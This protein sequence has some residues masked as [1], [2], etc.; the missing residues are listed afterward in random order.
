M[1]F[2]DFNDLHVAAGLDEV[3]RQLT[4]ALQGRDI[5][6]VPPPTPSDCEGR[7]SL[8]EALER[9]ILAMPD[10][11]V[12]DSRDK[13]LLR[14]TAARALMGKELFDAWLSNDERRSVSQE[15][16]APAAA[17]KRG[18]G[19]LSRALGRYVYLY[20]TDTV[21]DRQKRERVSISSL[22]YA[23]AKCY[24]DWLKHPE[25]TEIDVEN[26]VF[27]PTQKI[28]PETHIN[29]FR[30]L[31]FKRYRNDPACEG[32]RELLWHLCNKD[33][34]VFDW[35][36]CWLAY[37]LVHV[38]AKMGT[39]ILM[40]STIQGSGKSLMFDQVM[41]PIYGEYGATLGQHQLESQYTDW[42]SQKLYGLF[43]EVLS[44]DQKYS[45]TGTLKHMITGQ[46]H[47][48]EKKFVAGWEE[49]NH[50]NAVFLSNEVQPFP[51]E[52]ADR[53]M[54]VIW[55][56]QKLDPQLQA[57]VVA[58]CEGKGPQAFYSWLVD[59]LLAFPDFGTHTLPL[60]TEAKERLVDFGRP[61]WDV[62]LRAWRE[63]ELP[64]PFTPCLTSDL[65]RV[66]RQWCKQNGEH[67]MTQTKFSVLLA[68]EVPKKSD[69]WYKTK[70]AEKKGTV[71]MVT[72]PPGNVPK[73][74]WLGECINDFRR[75][76]ELETDY[77]P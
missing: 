37:P 69:Q 38:G 71:F 57:K 43:E 27:D 2:T 8:E 76:M 36:A 74:E 53:R 48:V 49:A 70:S 13:A 28:N 62:F 23:I 72:E 11:K 5:A 31:P 7:I 67:C 26:L 60:M 9:F 65:Y 73:S 66:Y 30:G 56:K 39:A 12:W 59:Y 64:V 6:A 4:K 55:P 47:R 40:H 1:S 46:T 22:R 33:D 32:I 21:W 17:A 19:E 18:G 24:D 75:K 41:R 58:E 68:A 45:H 10:A 44:R 63:G 34:A 51:V 54:M 15:L 16:V 61:G 25:R 14:Q 3:R 42:R 77:G 52:P 50:M 20:P 29:T 35:L